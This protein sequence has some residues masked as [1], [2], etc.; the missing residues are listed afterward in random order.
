MIRLPQLVLVSL[1]V[2]LPSDTIVAWQSG[3]DDPRMGSDAKTIQGKVIKVID[4]D[5]IV[6]QDDKEHSIEVQLEGLDAPEFQQP[7]GKESKELLSEK[8]LKK[9][10][11][12][13][14]EKEDNYK[15]KLGWVFHEDRNINLWMIEKGAAWHYAQ[16]NKEESFSNAQQVAKKAKLGL[17]DEA[18]PQPPWDYRRANRS[19]K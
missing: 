8:L 17:W 7:F 14:W 4:G 6:I 10:V 9:D 3:A 2:M 19:N 5:S 15:R 12:I 13:Q 11:S 16:Y 1:M 18:M